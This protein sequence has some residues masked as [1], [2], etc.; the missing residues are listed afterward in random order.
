M[1]KVRDQFRI[2]KQVR[3]IVITYYD[4]YVQENISRGK[5]TV[6]VTEFFN[7]LV[8]N[9]VFHYAQQI[10]DIATKGPGKWGNLKKGNL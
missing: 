3:D 2:S 1:N 6:D 5:E 4:N 7:Q 10:G 9:G 8:M